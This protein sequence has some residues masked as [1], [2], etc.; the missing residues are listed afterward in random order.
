MKWKTRTVG[1]MIK[2]VSDWSGNRRRKHS[3]VNHAARQQEIKTGENRCYFA[4][5]VSLPDN[6]VQTNM[7]NHYRRPPAVYRWRP[8]IETLQTDVCLIENEAPAGF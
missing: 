4:D 3:G 6:L 2:F 5:T 1:R 8:L 7:M